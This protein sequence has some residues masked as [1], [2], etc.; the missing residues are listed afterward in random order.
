MTGFYVLICTCIFRT[1]TIEESVAGNGLK[2]WHCAPEAQT[3][4][5]IIKTF[6]MNHYSNLELISTWRK[7]PPVNVW[8]VYVCGV[9]GCGSMWQ[10]DLYNR[11]GGGVLPTWSLKSSSVRDSLYTT[12]DNVKCVTSCP[13][14]SEI[15]TEPEASVPGVCSSHTWQPIRGDCFSCHGTESGFQVKLYP[16]VWVQLLDLDRASLGKSRRQ[17]CFYGDRTLPCCGP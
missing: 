5:S 3:W 4:V 2:G 7:P 1:V 15:L 11:V 6:F 9:Y 8:S 17:M 13:W 16:P 14:M 12:H 10:R